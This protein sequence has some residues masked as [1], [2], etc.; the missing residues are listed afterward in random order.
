MKEVEVIGGNL[1]LLGKQYPP[2]QHNLN[3]WREY[4]TTNNKSI[5]ER[6]STVVLD[7]G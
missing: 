6:L 3:V 5:L 7:L 2:T 1:Y 4:Q